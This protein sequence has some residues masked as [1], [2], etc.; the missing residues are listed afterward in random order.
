MKALT[1]TRTDKPR[2][3]IAAFLAAITVYTAAGVTTI[4]SVATDAADITIAAAAP[5]GSPTVP[6]P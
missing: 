5:D 6:A 1:L 4:S 3:V 2:V